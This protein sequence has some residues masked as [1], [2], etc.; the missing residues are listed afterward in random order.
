MKSLKNFVIAYQTY[1][2][3]NSLKMEDFLFCLFCSIATISVI[4]YQAI[5]KSVAHAQTCIDVKPTITSQSF[6]IPQTCPSLGI[7]P[8]GDHHLCVIQGIAAPNEITPGLRY[9]TVKVISD[10]PYTDTP[11]PA[12]KTAWSLQGCSAGNLTTARAVCIDW[13]PPL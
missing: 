5:H 2:K 8:L 4:S 3:K 10:N 12:Q 7:F 11:S 1:R 13:P 6:V 9:L